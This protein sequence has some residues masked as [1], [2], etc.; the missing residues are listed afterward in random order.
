[1]HVEHSPLRLRVQVD[2]D[3]KATQELFSLEEGPGLQD[4]PESRQ[5]AHGGLHSGLRVDVPGHGPLEGRHA[6]VEFLPAA[7]DLNQPLVDELPVGLRE[8]G[9]EPVGL[10]LQ[11][12]QFVPSAA[13]LLAGL[14]GGPAEFLAHVVAQQVSSALVQNL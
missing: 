1:M 13:H 5:A 7:L 10:G 4:L 11:S 2:A 8:V 12:G 14:V 6:R 3:D 9:Q